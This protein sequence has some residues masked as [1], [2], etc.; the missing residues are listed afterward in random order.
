MCD[1]ILLVVDVPRSL[2]HQE[3]R[4]VQQIGQA[5]PCE[6]V[7]GQNLRDSVTFSS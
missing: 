4:V 6:L 5:G 3:A 1:L 7:P 2:T